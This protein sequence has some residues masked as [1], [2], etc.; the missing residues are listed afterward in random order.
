MLMC[1]S[2]KLV[3]LITSRRYLSNNVTLDK[4]LCTTRYW[5][6][7]RFP[8]NEQAV[9]NLACQQRGKDDPEWIV[10]AFDFAVFLNENILKTIL[11]FFVYIGLFLLLLF[12]AIYFVV[13]FVFSASYLHWI[14]IILHVMFLDILYCY[15]MSVN[16]I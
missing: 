6:C 14:V 7:Q 9:F 8:Y 4:G 10:Q 12:L 1:N 2:N 11:F 3:L 15:S 13:V 5:H 16:R